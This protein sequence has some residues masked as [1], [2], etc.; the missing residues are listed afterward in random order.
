MYIIVRPIDRP[1]I[2]VY[3]KKGKRIRKKKKVNGPGIHGSNWVKEKEK[4][5]MIVELLDTRHRGE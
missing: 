2:Q 1:G 4:G 5:P 3:R